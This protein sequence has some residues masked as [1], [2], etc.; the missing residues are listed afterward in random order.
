MCQ[1][2]Q[3][4]LEDDL[5]LVYRDVHRRQ[6]NK[7]LSGWKKSFQTLRHKVQMKAWSHCAE[8][9]TQTVSDLCV[10]KKKRSNSLCTFEIQDFLCSDI[11]HFH[12]VFSLTLTHFFIRYFADKMTAFQ[13][14][15]SHSFH[16]FGSNI[17]Q[18]LRTPKISKILNLKNIFTRQTLRN[19]FLKWLEVLRLKQLFILREV[20]WQIPGTEMVYLL[21]KPNSSLLFC[22]MLILSLINFNSFSSQ[23]RKIN[24]IFL[25]HVA[26]CVS[27][28]LNM[29][30]KR[31]WIF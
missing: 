15:S 14:E 20:T 24:I 13:E 31:P 16:F 7:S 11:P 28:C 17:L 8:W 26:V 12:Q 21:T 4:N 23:T 9:N 30:L 25:F 5:C 27:T 19:S 1:S 29:T 22:I 2:A 6:F 18:K 10:W 3:A